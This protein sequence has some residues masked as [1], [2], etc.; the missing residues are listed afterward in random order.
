MSSSVEIREDDTHLIPTS[1]GRRK[2]KIPLSSVFLF[3]ARDKVVEIHHEKGMDLAMGP[4]SSLKYV[5]EKFQDRVIRTHR[6]CVVVAERLHSIIGEGDDSW[7]LMDGTKLRAPVSRRHISSVKKFI[8]E[9]FPLFSTGDRGEVRGI[10]V[11]RV[12]CIHAQ[13]KR[14]E[15]YYKSEGILR[16]HTVLGSTKVL[17][18]KLRGHVVRIHRNTLVG[19]Q[20]V[21]RVLETPEGGTALALK[22]TEM[23]FKVS[24]HHEKVVREMFLTQEQ[25]AI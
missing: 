22:N 10:P 14:L 16:K 17:E 25:E 15:V 7:A 2:E 18:K 20:Y 13:N 24:R 12:A 8:M 6:S 19:P 1:L 23:K 11:E 3:Q 9:S 4:Y 21:A 5:E